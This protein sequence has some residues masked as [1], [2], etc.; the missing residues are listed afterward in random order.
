[1]TDL[2]GVSH[3]HR[4]T[5]EVATL[6]VMWDLCVSAAREIY[7]TRPPSAFYAYR[8]ARLLFGTGA[9]ESGGFFYNRQIGF[10]FQSGEGGHGYWQQE[11]G[12]ILECKGRL[13]G[14]AALRL[15]AAKWFFGPK[16][17]DDGWYTRLNAEELLAFT[18]VSPRLSCLWARLYYMRDPEPV[19]FMAEEQ[20][21]YWGR[22]YNTREEPEKNAKWLSDYWHYMTMLGL[23]PAERGVEGG[24]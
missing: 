5:S 18:C 17:V 24:R 16:D 6:R 11:V 8:V 22:V 10:G 12:A 9:H 13:D 21:V 15:E 19:P 14:S 23:S 4:M 2:A 3:E 1:M 20:A 7:S